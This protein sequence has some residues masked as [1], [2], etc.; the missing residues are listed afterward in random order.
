MAGGSGDDVIRSLRRYVSQMLGSPPWKVRVGRVRVADDE[1]PVAVI[2]PSA[3]VTTLFARTG[4]LT[5]GDVQKART[6]T[7]VCYPAVGAT[8]Q[9]SALLAE[10]LSEL[11]DASF[12]RGLVTDSIPQ[13][14]IGA[15]FRVPMYDFA[16]VPMTGPDRGGASESYGY[17]NVTESGFNVRVLQDVVDE[18]RYT[19]V[20]TVPLTWWRAGRIAVE[21]PT[22]TNVP[23]TFDPGAFEHGGFV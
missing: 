17:A 15:P 16:D 21:G 4:T 13:R 7:V 6:L 18:L 19:V 1:R 5:Q 23:P 10:Q 14:L 8:P 9:D 3:P 22:V 2:D 11:L 20:A 12:E